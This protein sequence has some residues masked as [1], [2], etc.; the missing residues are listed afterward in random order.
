MC[1]AN[2]GIPVTLVETSDKLAQAAI[3]RIESTYKSSSAY[4]NGTL[5]DDAVAKL[6]ACITPS[7]DMKAVGLADMVIEAVFENME[8]KKDIF[9][10]L[11][12]I[13]KKGAILATNTSY[14][15]VDEI[16]NLTDR[17]ESVIGTRKCIIYSHVNM[18]LT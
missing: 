12:A 16:A 15:S 11:E 7:G 17:P 13:C 18:K 1:F 4:K 10:K 8:V 9:R 2:A 6:L 5:S 14:L 3:N